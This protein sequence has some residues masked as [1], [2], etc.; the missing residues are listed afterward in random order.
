MTAVENPIKKRKK[1][2][3]SEVA[4]ILSGVLV[5]WIVFLFGYIYINGSA[6]LMAFRHPD[7][8][9]TLQW[10]KQMYE[11]FTTAGGDLNIA[12]GNTMLTFAISFITIVPRSFV[13]YFIYKKIP[14]HGVY[15]ILFMLP[16]IIF[17]VAINMVFTQLVS[18][19]G[20][21]AHLIGDWLNLPYVPELLAD[22]R[23]AKWVIQ[24]HSLWLS[25]AGNLII[26]G[27]AYARIPVEVVESAQIDGVNWTKE[28]W[29]ITLPL[30]WPTV[31]L[32]LVMMFAS[33]LSQTGQVFLLTQGEYQT[34]TLSVWLYMQT[35]TGAG[36]PDSPVF[37][38]LSAVGLVMTIISIVLALT[39]RKITNKMSSGVDF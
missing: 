33:I 35:L 10:F 37:N 5:P 26:M 34:Q 32:Q 2:S 4:F 36:N 3:R 11:S 38:Y 30:I 1:R 19:S 7:G 12:L 15:R 23:F 31:Q 17:D 27:G 24:A 29:Y 8:F 39:V 9:W 20:P 25:F 16:S 14:F 6:L 18:P 13:A 28:F 22:S 21:I